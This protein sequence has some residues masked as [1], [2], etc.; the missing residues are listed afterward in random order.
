[1]YYFGVRRRQSAREARASERARA[2]REAACR[3]RRT[4]QSP[5]ARRPSLPLELAD[6]R[7]A[8]ARS[9]AGKVGR[10]DA[11]VRAPS[12]GKKGPDDRAA[13]GGGRGGHTEGTR[14]AHGGPPAASSADGPPRP[15]WSRG[16]PGEALAV[17]L[18]HQDLA[19][20]AQRRRPGPRRPKCS[21]AK[22]LSSAARFDARRSRHR[23]W[24][25]RLRPRPPGSRRP[26]SLP[27]AVATG[28][29][30]RH[31]SRR[32]RLWRGAGHPSV[33]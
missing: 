8:K 14:R 27:G 2:P 15:L 28:D 7:E 33:P 5:A 16:A 17:R 4:P 24:R 19:V 3:V 1:M 6:A 18:R 25:P 22:V 32:P 11:R 9:G 23:L 13:G 20:A 12:R 21:A 30:G 26:R 10:R 29:R 31:Q